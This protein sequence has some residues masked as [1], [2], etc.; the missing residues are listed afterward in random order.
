[1]YHE[2]QPGSPGRAQV[3]SARPRKVRCGVVAGRRMAQGRHAACKIDG[4]VA[5]AIGALQSQ[6]PVNA[7][8]CVL[9][10][11][12]SNLAHLQRFHTQ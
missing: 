2:A 1:M 10:P 4:A 9:V 5:R 7:L 11:S 8:H 6:G 12:E 3:V